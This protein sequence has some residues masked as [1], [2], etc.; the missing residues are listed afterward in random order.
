MCYLRVMR[1]TIEL[2]ASTRAGNEA[3]KQLRKLTE[4]KTIA[5]HKWKKLTAKDLALPGGLQPTEWQLEEYLNRK[6]GKGKPAK[7][8]FADIKKRLKDNF[9]K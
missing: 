5:I 8:A 1:Y 9:G 6:Q 7:K 3:L 2:D 4:D